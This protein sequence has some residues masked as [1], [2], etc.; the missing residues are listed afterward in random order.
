VV[1]GTGMIG[2]SAFN[3]YLNQHNAETP[4]RKHPIGFATSNQAKK[5]KSHHATHQIASL[6]QTFCCQ[7]LHYKL[8]GSEDNPYYAGNPSGEGAQ[9]FFDNSSSTSLK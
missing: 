1:T 2:Q 8:S 7:K 6:P 4:D 5:R 3:N 9:N